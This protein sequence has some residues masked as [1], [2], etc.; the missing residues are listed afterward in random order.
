MKNRNN[1]TQENQALESMV[2]GLQP[3]QP[4]TYTHIQTQDSHIHSPSGENN[5]TR[6]VGGT[7]PAHSHT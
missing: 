7:G 2:D 4:D 5:A 1:V 6:T 3:C